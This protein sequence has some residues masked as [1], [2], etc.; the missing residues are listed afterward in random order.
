M[1]FDLLWLPNVIIERQRT[2]R[3]MLFLESVPRC[4]PDL[5]AR[6]RRRASGS[7]H[8][9]TGVQRV[10][11][12][13]PGATEPRAQLPAPPPLKPTP[14][15]EVARSPEAGTTTGTTWQQAEE[16][17]GQQG[18][19]FTT[20]EQ[21]AALPV[22]TQLHVRVIK[23]RL[24]PKALVTSCALKLAFLSESFL[25]KRVSSGTECP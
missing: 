1:T 6:R 18:G 5:H 4:P 22:R 17:A 16:R 20:S 12:A 8:L 19:A 21:R 15:K 24:H 7:A 13:A 25:P 9:H 11:R 2:S 14:F 23:P 10:L 3:I